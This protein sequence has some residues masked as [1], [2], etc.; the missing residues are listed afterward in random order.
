MRAVITAE[1]PSDRERFRLAALGVGL[2]CRATDCIAPG[3]LQTRLSRE[4]AADL[5]LVG[6]TDPP[7]AAMTAL[8]YAATVAR[9][10]AVAIGPVSDAA[11]IHQASGAGARRYLDQAQLQGQ[12]SA[13]L[14]S[15]SKEGAVTL[16]RGKVI[17][18]TSAQPGAGVTTIATGLA[19]GLAAAKAG[20]VVLAELGTG[21][22]ELALSLGV[23][24]TNGLDQLTRL[25]ER[26]DATMC[27]TAAVAH[28]AGVAVLAYPPE[29]LQPEPLRADQ[30][31]PLLTVLRAAYDWVVLDLGHGTNDGN[32]DFLSQADRIVVVTRQDVPAVRLTRRYLKLLAVHPAD[33]LLLVANRYGQPG[34]LAWK[35]IEE[36]LKTP[37][38][39]WVPDDPAGV[40]AALAAGEPVAVAARGSAV[41]KCFVKLAKGLTDGVA[42]NK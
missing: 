7:A 16:R 13:A 8:G 4:P 34:H 9:T 21:V 6:M 11:L 32:D 23:T 14:D 28:P 39:E 27:R 22:P 35:K 10:V 20:N 30:A 36:A 31:R 17:A 29:T 25:S 1:R 37:V 12:L 33:R 26:V 3:E 5:V 41:N 19:F 40:N 24:P 15:L 42:A 2:E 38:A 18:V